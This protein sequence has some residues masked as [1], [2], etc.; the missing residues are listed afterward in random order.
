MKS[1]KRRINR[2]FRQGKSQEGFSIVEAMVS[3]FILTV[4][5][6]AA[7]S[8]LVSVAGSEKLSSVLT[9]ATNLS[10]EKLEKVRHKSYT[11]V[12]DE[13]EDFGGISKFPS[14]KRDV[15]VVSNLEDTMKTVEV[16]TTHL[17]GQ[18][19]TLVTLIRR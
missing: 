8:V 17:G 11:D 7:A 15:N 4:G 14:F 10:Q 9:T 19:V 6:M 13:T 3:V 16:V 1:L 12:D 2:H 5:L 18:S